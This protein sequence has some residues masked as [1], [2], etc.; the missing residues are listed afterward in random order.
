VSTNLEVNGEIRT[1]EV[2]DGKP[3]LWVLREDLG[4]QGAKFGCGA[5]MCGA[6]SVLVDG[7][8]VRSCIYP[9]SM[10]AGKSVRTIEGLNDTLGVR[11]KDA[12]V[13]KRV[14]QCGYCQTGQLIAAYALIDQESSVTKES[15]HGAMTNICRCGTYGRIREAIM[16]VADEMGGSK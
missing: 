15:I 13:S 3:L 12:W 6:C 1:V 9:A 16:D 5:G 10:A 4:L 2:E 14:P 7:D 8:V 11:L